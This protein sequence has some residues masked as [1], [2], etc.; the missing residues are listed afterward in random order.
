M[1]GIGSTFETNEPFVSEVL[2]Q[3]GLGSIQLPDF[4]RGWVWDDDRI[5][6]LIASVSQSYPIGALMLLDAGGSSGNFAPRLVQGVNING[7]VRKLKSLILDG[8]Q[9]LTSL[10]GALKGTRPVETRTEK[11]DPIQRYYYLN[12]ERC[13][14]EDADRTDAV[15][16]VPEDKVIRTDFNR[17]VKLD[18]SAPENEYAN[19]CFPL[20]AVFDDIARSNWMMGYQEHHGFQRDRVQFWNRFHTEII[21]RFLKYKV[22]VIELLGDT[23]KEAVCHVFENVNT[24]GVALT[25]FELLTAMFASDNFRLRADWDERKKRICKHDVLSDVSETDFVQSVTLYATYQRN[26]AGLGAVGAKRKD[27]LKLELED[28]KANAD[29]IEKGFLE[30]ARLLLRE[31]VFSSRN[32]PYQG[33]LIPLAAIFAI[34]GS[35]AEHEEVKRKLARWYWCGVFGELYGSATEARFALD[36]QQVPAWVRGGPEPRTVG[37]AVFAPTRFLTMQTRLSAAYK[38]FMARLMSLGSRDPRTGDPIEL[39]TYMD[40]SVDI[41]HLFPAAYCEEKQYDRRFWNSIINKAPITAK[42]NR[43]IGKQ[44]P[45]EYSARFAKAIGE[46]TLNDVLASHAL[47]PELLCGDKFEDFVR[48]R[49]ARLLDLIEHATGKP[50]AGRDSDEVVGYFGGPLFAG[51]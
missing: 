4:Q 25:V 34:L 22:P 31:K 47:R 49:A 14:D 41:H 48:D 20:S 28:Y 18:L 13:L 27:M 3:I 40:D 43:S 19:Q 5:R 50:V 51:T 9:R 35:D 44:A 21:Q 29:A 1:A 11:G 42:T 23:A 32:L 33:Q 36:V 16:G 15:I 26:Q 38:G 7:E 6:G 30:S 46:K 37:D 2:E 10:Y 12:M 24:G 45:S 17:V 39:T 8:Q